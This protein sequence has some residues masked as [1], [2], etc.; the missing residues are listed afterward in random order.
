MYVNIISN[1]IFIS[2]YFVDYF[3][4]VHVRLLAPLF[5]LDFLGHL[6]WSLLCVVRYSRIGSEFELCL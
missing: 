3:E 5:G 4:D 6:G 2:G 1:S